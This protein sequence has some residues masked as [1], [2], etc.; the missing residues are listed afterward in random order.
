MQNA[1]TFPCTVTLWSAYGHT[2][3][4]HREGLFCDVVA[5]ETINVQ[6]HEDAIKQAREM[7]KATPHAVKGHFYIREGYNQNLASRFFDK[8]D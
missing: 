5:L 3:I 8:Q 1:N 6:D 4:T 7:L 2:P